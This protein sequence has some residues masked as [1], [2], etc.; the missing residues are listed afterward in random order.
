MLTI[1]NFK[2]SSLVLTL[3]LQGCA[4]QLLGTGTVMSATKIKNKD[5]KPKEETLKG[6]V[7][8]SAVGAGTGAGA[9]AIAGGVV[10]T[11]VAIG[12]FGLG[13]I[14]LPAFISGGALAGAGIGAGAGAGVGAGAGYYADTHHQGIGLYQFSVNMDNTK[15]KYSIYQFIQKPIP[16]KTRV[17]VFLKKD[18]LYLQEIK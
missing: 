10:G 1:K 17:K 13:T 14:L 4:G 11:A 6:V 15:T 18:H 5:W 8:G 9:G 3:I 16:L 2:I 12:T 7:V